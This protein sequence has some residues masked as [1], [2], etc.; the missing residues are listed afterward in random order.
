MEWRA[1]RAGLDPVSRSGRERTV[2]TCAS[3]SSAWRLT[4]TPAPGPLARPRGRGRGSGAG[5]GARRRP[6]ARNLE[7]FGQPELGLLFPLDLPRGPRARGVAGGTSLRQGGALSVSSR[8]LALG[9]DWRRQRHR[10]GS[11][12]VEPLRRLGDRPRRQRQ[13][14]R[15]GAYPDGPRY[16]VEVGSLDISLTGS[17]CERRR[18]NSS[19]I[20]SQR[21]LELTGWI[22]LAGD[23]RL[24]LAGLARGGHCLPSLRR[25]DGDGLIRYAGAV[26]DS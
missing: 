2:V 7:D 5:V 6:V 3:T 16:A 18:A 20:A 14:L 11:A 4:E 23:H 22:P 12:A 17:A 19:R 8:A 1:E 15:P 13:D 21:R 26:A 9:L 25:L 10:D 24:W